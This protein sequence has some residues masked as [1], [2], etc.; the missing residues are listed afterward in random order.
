M[1]LSVSMRDPRVQQGPHRVREQSLNRQE[2]R[3]RFGT[4]L[5]RE[6]YGHVERRKNKQFADIFAA[7]VAGNKTIFQIADEFDVDMR[8]VSY[9]VRESLKLTGSSHV[10]QSEE[11]SRGSAGSLEHGRGTVS[12]NEAS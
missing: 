4:Q 7:Y 8:R 12:S 10:E 6:I 2:A 9:I 1:R 11:S 5:S 3:R